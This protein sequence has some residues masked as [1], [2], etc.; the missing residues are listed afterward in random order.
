MNNRDLKLEFSKYWETNGFCYRFDVTQNHKITSF[1]PPNSLKNV[2]NESNDESD[3][4]KVLWGKIYKLDKSFKLI[5]YT[6]ALKDSNLLKK[7][8]EHI[9]YID[10]P[11]N[12]EDKFLKISVTNN[13]YYCEVINIG[14]E[15]NDIVID[16]GL[17]EFFKIIECEK[18]VKWADVINRY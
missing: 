3:T 14:Y 7:H 15:E 6:N 5:E 13:K 2:T 18:L 8:F 16:S 10:D 9:L 11:S 1:A 17:E 4:L 12:N